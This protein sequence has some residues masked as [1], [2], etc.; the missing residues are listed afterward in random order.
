[1]RERGRRPNGLVVTLAVL[2]TV[3]SL[4][5]AGVIALFLVMHVTG[6]PEETATTYLT[7]CRSAPTARWTR[8][9]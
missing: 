8:S 9:P 5:V 2:G 7:D 4:V 3:A 1:M 6:S